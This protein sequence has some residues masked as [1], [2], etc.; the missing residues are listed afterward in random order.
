MHELTRV[1]LENDMDIILAHRRAMKLGELA[2][3]SLAAQT[4][5]ATA[6]SEICRYGVDFLEGPALRLLVSPADKLILASIEG[7]NVIHDKHHANLAYARRL[8]DRFVVRDQSIETG[9]RIPGMQKVTEQSIQ[10]W[11]SSFSHEYPL[12]PYDEI[13]RKNIQL[14]QLSE[15]LRES[16][17]QYKQLSESIPLMIFKLNETGELLYANQWLLDF[18]GTTIDELRTTR[19]RQVMHPD[20]W[21]QTGVIWENESALLQPIHFEYRFLQHA[22]GEYIWHMASA[23]PLKDNSGTTNWIGYAVNIHHQKIIEQAL[24]DNHELK[25]IQDQLKS[26]QSELEIKLYELNRSNLELAQFAYVA[27]HDL[28]EPL[29]KLMVYSEYLQ[30]K[31]SSIDAQGIHILDNMIG[32]TTRMKRLIEDLLLF[33]RISAERHNFSTVPLGQLIHDV[34]EDFDLHVEEKHVKIVADDLPEIY[35]SPAHLKQVFANLLSN[36]IKYSKAGLA[37][38]ITITANRNEQ[39]VTIFFSDNGIG[40]EEKY[41]DK[42]FGMFQRLH[43]R[44]Q[45]EGTGIGLSITKKIIE[46][47]KGTITAQSKPGK[48]ATFIISLP[49][50]VKAGSDELAVASSE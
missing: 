24:K 40:F 5:F 4:T 49:N 15:K 48:G 50:E 39:D 13:K 9:F 1:S 46:M 45:F 11:A 25:T 17:L 8:A 43:T 10:L 12:S 23:I 18:T 21:K 7:I 22:T 31:Y 36:A 37:P 29:R 28:Q 16:E 41:A 6:V 38:E 47:H 2:G 30:K 34:I 42:I 20:D 32:A 44:E 33:S 26:Y 14:Q 27:S 19:W 3:L 35:G